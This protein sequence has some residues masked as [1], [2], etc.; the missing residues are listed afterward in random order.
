MSARNS[1]LIFAT[2]GGG[3]ISLLLGALASRPC[4]KRATR[5]YIL[6]SLGCC[7]KRKTLFQ[8]QFEIKPIRPGSE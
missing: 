6:N 5:S 1:H 7:K 2:D 4:T 3:L 8:F